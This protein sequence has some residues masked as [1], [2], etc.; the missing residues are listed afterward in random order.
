MEGTKQ[1]TV[2]DLLTL[3]DRKGLVAW[4]QHWLSLPVLSERSTGCRSERTGST[5]R[6]RNPSPGRSSHGPGHD[7]RQPERNPSP[8]RSSP[9]PA[10]NNRQPLPLRTAHRPH[11][12][13]TLPTRSIVIAT[14]SSVPARQ[15]K[16]TSTPITVSNKN[17]YG[18]NYPM[19]MNLALWMCVASSRSVTNPKSYMPGALGR[20]KPQ[21][22]N[23]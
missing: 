17:C 23:E 14:Y 7:N 13:V 19:L 16:G 10:H 15:R 9:E 1:H 4:R 6:W 20:G 12:L 11:F 2:G 21:P 8:R 5:G 3:G 22:A 18:W